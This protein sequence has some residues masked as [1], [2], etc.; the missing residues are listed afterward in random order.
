MLGQLQRTNLNHV[1]DT[2]D[3]TRDGFLTV[4]DF[5]TLAQRMRGL[6]PAMDGRLAADIDEAFTSWWEV[7]R[8]AADKDGDGKI[9]R[10]EFLTAVEEG[11]QNDPA[12]ADRMARVCEVTF[13]AA[14]TNEDGQLS[15]SEVQQIYRAYGVDEKI[16]AETFAR[17]DRDGNGWISVEEFVQASRDVYLSNDADAPGTALFGATS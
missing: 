2:L 4:D 9:T 3:L 13:A 8:S 14:D 17:L 7:F 11:L 10:D 1:F 15:A 5:T 12:Y 6:R 16:S